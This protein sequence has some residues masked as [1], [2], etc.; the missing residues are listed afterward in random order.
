VDVGQHRAGSDG[1]RRSSFGWPFALVALLLLAPSTGARAE[2]VAYAFTAV[3][4]EIQAPGAFPEGFPA[5]GDV[6]LGS[7]RY[8]SDGTG[9]TTSES[10]SYRLYQPANGFYLELPSKLDFLGAPITIGLTRD[11]KGEPLRGAHLLRIGSEMRG[12]EMGWPF[13]VARVRVDLVLW[14]PT[15]VVASE[16][17]LPTSVDLARFARAE[18][19]VIGS[20]GPQDVEKDG[21]L[22]SIRGRIDSLT[23]IPVSEAIPAGAVSPSPES[24]AAGRSSEDAVEPSND[25]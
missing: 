10:A 2:S 3:V 12:K 4:T 20:W 15:R 7:F 6:V 5:D 1:E 25:D 19:G 24:S 8:E 23:P 13:Q 17:V 16:L 11:Y 9:R 14:D 18:F 21:P 22:W